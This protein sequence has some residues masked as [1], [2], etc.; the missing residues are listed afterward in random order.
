MIWRS[1]SRNVAAGSGG[2]AIRCADVANRAALAS[3]RNMATPP[4]GM[5]YA[6]SPSKIS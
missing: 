4:S 2:I 3:G 6:F 5:V 1:D